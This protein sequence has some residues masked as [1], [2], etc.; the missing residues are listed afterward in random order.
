M[1]N[2]MPYLP[3]SIE[4]ILRQKYSDFELL[5]INDGSTDDSLAY[6]QSVR[7]PRLRVISQPNRGISCALNR[8][9]EEARAPWLVRLDADDIAHPDRLALLSETIRRHPNAGMF[10][11]EAENYGHPHSISKLRTSQGTPEELRK[12][13]EEGYLL[14]ICHVT[15]VLNVAKTRELGGYR[16]NL[17][18]EDLDLWWRMALHHRIVFIPKVTV[19]VR[20]RCDS[21]CVSN[22]EALTLNT[23]YAQYLLLSHLWRLPALAYETAAQRLQR[24]IDKRRL[25]YRQQM[26]LAGEDLAVSQYRRAMTHIL[27]AMVTSPGD[28]VRRAKSAFLREKVVHRGEDPAMFRQFQDLLWTSEKATLGEAV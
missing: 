21:T 1:F 25:R 7:D 14:R 26:W 18:I 20:L 6:L 12:V 2:G 15:A 16:F 9:L 3:E 17:L 19:S 5:V 22:L 10:Y 28:F 4:S 13:T 8:A 24:L 23:L 11:S 27:H